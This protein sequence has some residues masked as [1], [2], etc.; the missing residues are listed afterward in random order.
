MLMGEISG[1]LGRL[2]DLGKISSEYDIA[3]T[4]AC[5]ALN[6]FVVEVYVFI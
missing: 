2:G 5:P 3:I 6:N 4:S 1:Y